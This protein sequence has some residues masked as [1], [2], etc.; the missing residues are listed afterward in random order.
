MRPSLVS[1]SAFR[2]FATREARARAK[3][4]EARGSGEV[5]IEQIYAHFPF[6]LFG[7][8][9]SALPVLVEAEFRAEIGWLHRTGFTAVTMQQ[10]WDSWHGGP[11]LPAHPVMVTLD[12]GFA[13]WYTSVMPVLRTY[14]WPANMEVAASHLDQPGWGLT[15]AMVNRLVHTYGWEL[16]SHTLTHADLPGGRQAVRR[17]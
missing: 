9:V 8:D 12:D 4:K 15:D 17:Q 1:G 13:D 14:G 10:W 16:D 11:A 5:S 3:A 7:T 6:R 2:S